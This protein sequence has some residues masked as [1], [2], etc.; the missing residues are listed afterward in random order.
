[1]IM[2]AMSYFCRQNLSQN[3]LEIHVVAN[4]SLSSEILALQ[5]VDLTLCML[6]NISSVLS[7]ADIFSKSYFLKISFKI[8][9][10][11]S[12]SSLAFVGPDS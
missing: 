11:G 7:P 8:T 6:C 1:M 2:V 9:Q 4:S 5:L 10:F 3:S 12:I